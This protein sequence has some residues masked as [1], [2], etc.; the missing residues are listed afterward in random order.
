MCFK[1]ECGDDGVGPCKMSLHCRLDQN[2]NVL[3][4]HPVYSFPSEVDSVFPVFIDEGM[5]PL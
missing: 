2:V 5:G 3:R 4:G 1:W